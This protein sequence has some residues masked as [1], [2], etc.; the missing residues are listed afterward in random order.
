MTGQGTRIYPTPVGSRG[1]IQTLW[2]VP[3]NGQGVLNV[4]CE[5]FL[6]SHELEHG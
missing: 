1:D 3:H 5:H 4:G 6:S 2:K